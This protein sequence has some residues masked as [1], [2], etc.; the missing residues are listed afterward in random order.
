MIVTRGLGRP[1]RGAIVAFGLGLAAS[2]VTQ[3]ELPPTLIVGIS[4]PSSQFVASGPSRMVSA[5]YVNGND[6]NNSTANG[7][8]FEVDQHPNS[9]SGRDSSLFVSTDRKLIQ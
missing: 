7:R 4:R 2:V 8:D 9:T 1:T 5:G 3:T 6:P